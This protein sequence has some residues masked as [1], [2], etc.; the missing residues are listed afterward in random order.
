ML[1]LFTSVLSI[2]LRTPPDYSK[3]DTLTVVLTLTGI[4]V[5]TLC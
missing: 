5:L 1:E 2:I 4:V 3:C